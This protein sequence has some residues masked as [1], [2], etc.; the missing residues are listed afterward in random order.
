MLIGKGGGMKAVDIK[1]R[2]ALEKIPG[3]KVRLNIWVKAM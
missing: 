1:A 3:C 2:L